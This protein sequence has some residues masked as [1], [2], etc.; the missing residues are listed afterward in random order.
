MKDSC[1]QIAH[2]PVLAVS[3]R[4]CIVEVYLQPSTYML[5]GDLEF[6]THPHRCAR[7]APRANEQT[8]DSASQT[9]PPLFGTRWPLQETPT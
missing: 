6:V 8:S 3:K 9:R 7:A 5:E 2:L 4:K 1:Y